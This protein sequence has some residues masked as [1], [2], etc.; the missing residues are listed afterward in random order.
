MKRGRLVSTHIIGD[1]G[2]GPDW[3]SYLIPVY[4][5]DVY[6]RISFKVGD[7]TAG[8]ILNEARGSLVQVLF[9]SGAG[10]IDECWLTEVS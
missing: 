3:R 8:I 10:W 9:P 1:D 4:S 7:K 2:D 6:K 5:N